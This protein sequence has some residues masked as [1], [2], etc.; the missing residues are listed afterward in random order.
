MGATTYD[1]TD[2]TKTGLAKE[3]FDALWTQVNT[4]ESDVAGHDH[5][6]DY[7]ALGH[8]HDYLPLSGGVMT[9]TIWG[10]QAIVVRHAT[11]PSFWLV[12]TTDAAYT[13]ILRQTNANFD[14]FYNGGRKWRYQSAS[15]VLELPCPASQPSGFE[16][17]RVAFYQVE[18]DDQLW[19]FWKESGGG[20][21]HAMVADS[22]RSVLWGNPAAA[23]LNGTSVTNSYNMPVITFPNGSTTLASW[24]WAVPLD[25][26]RGKIQFNL[27]WSNITASVNGN[28]AIYGS[29][30]AWNT[31]DDIVTPS[32]QLSIIGTGE[33]LITGLSDQGK[34][35]QYDY[36]AASV[37]TLGTHDF[38]TFRVQRN[39]GDGSDSSGQ[40]WHV[41]GVRLRLILTD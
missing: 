35:G 7:A 37:Q 31:G 33:Q 23:A 20:N 12:D 32:G 19:A 38:I 11:D 40:P 30:S 15:D 1:W 24:S 5:D 8:G 26:D 22:M 41:L 13:S 34:I 10:D 9:G 29:M 36:Q 14:Y 6:G 17:G 25:W 27:F 16:N 18:G 21:H 2:K 4:N 28:H 39:G 3:E